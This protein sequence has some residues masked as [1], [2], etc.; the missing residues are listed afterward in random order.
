M[1]PSYSVLLGENKPDACG[2]DND[3]SS[4]SINSTALIATFVSIIGLA[5]LGTAFYFVVY[6]K[7]KLLVQL[8]SADSQTEM[9][10]IKS[11]SSIN[12]DY[13]TNS[14]T[15]GKQKIIGKKSI[16]KRIGLSQNPEESIEIERA[17]S[18]EVN[19]ASGRFVV[20]L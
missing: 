20:N 15:T 9:Q 6:P 1:D 16:K 2:F 3:K 10:R 13:N 12:E 18:M 8:R 19:T 11:N 17:P 5:I 14:N 4:N 7:L